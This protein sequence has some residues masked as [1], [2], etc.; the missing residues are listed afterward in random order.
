MRNSFLLFITVFLL[1]LTSCFSSDES[2]EV[3][4]ISQQQEQTQ[5]QFTTENLQISEEPEFVIEAEYDPALAEKAEINKKAKTEKTSQIALACVFSFFTV[6]PSPTPT[7][8][9]A[10]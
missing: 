2:S 8:L 5:Q 6:L 4:D 9:C 1:S 7:S 3:T 10:T